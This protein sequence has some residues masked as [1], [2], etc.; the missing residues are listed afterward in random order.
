MYGRVDISY[1]CSS[2]L[3]F[4]S[5][6]IGSCVLSIQTAKGLIVSSCLTLSMQI[7]TVWIKFTVARFMNVYL[8]R[9]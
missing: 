3:A 2:L 9:N 8:D 6:D 1:R 4:C 5:I 7:A